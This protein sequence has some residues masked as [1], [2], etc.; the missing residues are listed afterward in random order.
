METSNRRTKFSKGHWNENIN[1]G[2]AYNLWKVG[3]FT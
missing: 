2:F 1:I 3:R